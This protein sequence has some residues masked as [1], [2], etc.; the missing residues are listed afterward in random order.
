MRVILRSYPCC[1]FL[2]QMPKWSHEAV[3][4]NHK[5]AIII[6]HTQPCLQLLL[7]FWLLKVP[8]IRKFFGCRNYPFQDRMNPRNEISC[9]KNSH[10]FRLIV[11][12][13]S[14]KLEKSSNNTKRCS[15]KVSVPITASSMYFHK[16]LHNLRD[17]L[18]NAFSMPLL[19]RY[20]LILIRI[21]LE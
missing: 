3:I 16:A 21:V 7:F 13:N 9:L 19:M 5:S 17:A 11:K 12:L 8:N 2:E 18:F 15:L 10:L 20:L 4:L 1:I 6:K 14:N